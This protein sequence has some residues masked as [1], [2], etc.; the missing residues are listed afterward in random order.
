MNDAVENTVKDIKNRI[1]SS[2][3]A[4]PSE[5]IGC[6]E[7]E[8]NELELFFGLHLPSAY[9]A[10]LKAMGRGAGRLMRDAD[11]FSEVL[12][13]LTREASEILLD[14]EMSPLPD[15]AFVFGIRN[16]EQFLFFICDG[17]EDPVIFR[18][19][20]GNNSFEKKYSSFW[21]FLRDE[22]RYLEMI[23]VTKSQV[24]NVR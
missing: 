15:R 9:K 23:D 22:I 3:I 24:R 7:E 4:L 21:D 18:F 5:I 8:V 19:M 13:K 2:K 11:V 20:E 10:F 17:D 16:S 6:T 14:E 1:I 12:K